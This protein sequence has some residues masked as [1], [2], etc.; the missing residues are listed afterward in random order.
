M[1]KDKDRNRG[2]QSLSAVDIAYS[3][4]TFNGHFVLQEFGTRED[5]GLDAWERLLWRK[6]RVVA[7]VDEAG[8]GPLAG[9]ALCLE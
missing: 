5:T 8:R 1:D 4:Q 6:T 7:G 3:L 2:L 9:P